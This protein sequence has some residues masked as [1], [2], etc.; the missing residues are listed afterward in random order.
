MSVFDSAAACKNSNQSPINLSQSGA[1]P[2]NILCDLVFDDAYIAQ[3][4]VAVTQFG[5]MIASSTNL[6]SCKYNGHSYSCNLVL[7][8]RPSHHT[9]DGIQAEGEVIAYFK[10][11]TEGNLC[12]SS[13]FRVNPGKTHS[14]HFFNAFIPY[15][16]SE[17]PTS[18][19]LGE[20]WGLFMMVPPTGSYYV[21]DGV[22]LDG[23]CSST[24]WVVFK[25]MINIDQ[26]DFALLVRNTKSQFRGI[27]SLGDRKI[28]YN[29]VEQL[30][31]G[32]MPKD[33]KTYMRCKRTGRKNN[34]V[35]NVSSAPLQENKPSTGMIKTLNEWLF[36]QIHTNG[37]ISIISFLFSILAIG[38]GVYYGWKYTGTYDGLTIS[39]WAQK[40]GEWIRIPF[41]WLYNMLFG[42]K[43]SP[44]SSTPPSEKVSSFKGMNPAFGNP[45][46]TPKSKR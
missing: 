13:L 34:D 39:R 19:S 42:A 12:V 45:R 15:G 38:L 6:G 28:F 26:N 25:H 43:T 20:Q 31:G 9:I 22:T 37:I 24:K 10:S 33:G 44:L 35:K 36:G 11:P 2:C 7:V 1:E 41:E 17:N 40:L 46:L 14:I 30:T 4:N 21:Y 3:A 5:L 16:N 8:N 23:Q 27:Q 32:P 18:I 29:D